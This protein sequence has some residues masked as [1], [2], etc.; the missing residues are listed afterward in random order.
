MTIPGLS[1]FSVPFSFTP[2]EIAE[3]DSELIILMNEKIQWKYPIIGITETLALNKTFSFKTQARVP[4]FQKI[5]VV[6]QGLSRAI[7]DF[8]QE[9]FR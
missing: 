2:K 4:V 1:N 3:Y 9:K 7:K 5:S 8:K 6:L